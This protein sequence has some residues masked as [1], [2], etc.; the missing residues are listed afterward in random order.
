MYALVSFALLMFRDLSPRRQLTWAFGLYFLATDVILRVRWMIGQRFMVARIPD[1]PSAWIYGHGTMTQIFHQ[2]LL[3]VADW[4]G[5]WGLTSYFGVLATFLA[6]TWALRSG[7]FQRVVNDRRT[8]WRFLAW[9]VAIAG[10]QYGGGL[11]LERIRASGPPSDTLTVML[12]WRRL[13]R[14][15]FDPTAAMG[16]AYAA[17]LLLIFQT[18][19]G[20]RVLAPLVSTGRMALTTYLTQSVVCTLLFYSFG[21]G[22]YGRVRYTGMFAITLSLFAI[23]LAANS[24][25]LKRYRFGPVEWLWRTLTYGRAPAMRIPRS[26]ADGSMQMT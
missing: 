7:F 20:A 8:T 19:R 2:R 16:L 14:T 25:W 21:L 6:G 18:S 1:Q 24:W 4:Y 9:C 15:P 5:R 3:D 11:L 12:W 17:V 26:S 22:W 23:Q 13:V 10:I